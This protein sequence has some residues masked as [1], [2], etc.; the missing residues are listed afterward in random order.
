M[1]SIERKLDTS[2]VLIDQGW[3]ER[4]RVVVD[5]GYD[6]GLLAEGLGEELAQ[7]VTRGRFTQQELRAG[8]AWASRFD[9]ETVRLGIVIHAV[10]EVCAEDRIEAAARRVAHHSGRQA[11]KLVGTAD[12][13]WLARRRSGH[14]GDQG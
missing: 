12:K 13:L 5:Y 11:L 4:A 9:Q 7:H 1:T 14:L 8:V 6:I 10:D 3:Y 2:Q